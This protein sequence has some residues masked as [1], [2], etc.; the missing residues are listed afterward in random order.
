ME[1]ISHAFLDHRSLLNQPSKVTPHEAQQS[2]ASQLKE[3]L[4]RVNDAQQESD[5]KTVAL[6]QGKID[7]L[8][9]VMIAAQKASITLQTTVEIQNKAIEA[10]KEIMRMQI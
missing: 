2:F 9:D 1:K 5:Q 3:A 4:E 8:H 7:N 6:A 10:Y